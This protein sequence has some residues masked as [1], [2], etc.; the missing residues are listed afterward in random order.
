MSRPL[1]YLPGPI[2]G[3]TQSEASDWRAWPAAELNRHG[4][5]CISPTRGQEAVERFGSGSELSGPQTCARVLQWRSRFDVERADGLLM[6]LL[7]AVEISAGSAYEAGLADAWGKPVVVVM[8]KGNVNWKLMLAEGATIV[9]PTIEQ[10]VEVMVSF[11]A[12]MT[13]GAKR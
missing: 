4:T 13:P 7:G 9:V 5:G 3:C 2:T 6:C 1:I 10:G 8:N 12:N 11:F